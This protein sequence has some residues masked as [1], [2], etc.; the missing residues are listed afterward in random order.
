[1]QY[2]SEEAATEAIAKTNEMEFEGK[3]LEVFAHVKRAE[4][5]DEPK[6]ATGNNIFV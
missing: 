4:T 5:A 3:K 1:M 2:K 6:A